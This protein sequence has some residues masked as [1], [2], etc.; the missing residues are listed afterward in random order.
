MYNLENFTKKAN[1]VIN[2]AFLQAGKLGHTYVGSEHLLLSLVSEQGSTAYNI[3]KS[4]GIR[5]D[6]VLDRLISLV[7][8]GDSTSV[9][10]NS[11]TPAARKTIEQSLEIA[12]SSG[13]RLAGTEHLLLSL[14]KQDNCT[15]LAIIRDIGGS[16][17]KIYNACAGL[18][19]VE[20]QVYNPILKAPTLMKYGRDLTQLAK[21][22]KCDPVF[23]RD[24][25]IER[26]MQILSRRTKNNPCL[27]GEA[28]VGKTAVV[29]GIAAL[30]AEGKV[31][32]TIKNKRIFS[33]NLT[34][35]LAGAKY[36]GDFEERIKQCIDEVIENGNIILFIDELHTIVGAGAAEGAIDAA[37]ILKPQLA[38]G[39]LQII[40]ATTIEE[41][42]KY[43]EKDSALERRFQQVLIKE[44]TPEEAIIIL[45]GLSKC[46]EDYHNVK[47][48][49]EA[50]SAAVKMSVRYIQ[51]RY[52]PDK[53]IDLID[54]AASRVR[55]KAASSPQSLKEL[56]ESLKQILEN[57]P[58][59]K[60]A[61]SLPRKKSGFDNT[62]WYSESEAK[63]IEVTEKD[64]AEVLSVTKGIPVTQ[65]TQDES[66]C[67]LSLES[68]LQKRVIGQNEAVKAVADAIRRSRS[69]LK[70]PCR[71]IG[72]FLFLGP[73]GVGKTELSKALA[74]CLFNEKNALI[75]FDMSEFM[76]KHSIAKLIGSPPG[77][78]G[79]D[80]GAQ[81]TEKVRRKP[82]SV[83][84]FDEIEK[85]HPDIFNILLQIFEDG[86]LTDST[87][88]TVSFRD[89][90]II[91][92]SNIGGNH[93]T[94]GKTVGFSSAEES[95]YNS[96]KHDVMNE[97]KNNFRPELL[98][99]IEE[100]IIF[101]RL[102]K[103]QLS[104]ITVK[105][106]ENL[107]ERANSLEIAVEFS[108]EAIQKLSE[109]GFDKNG[110]RKLRHIITTS[111]ENL[112]S[113]Q[114][115]EGT[116]K[117]GDNVILTLVDNNY[118]F[119]AKQLAT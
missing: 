87:G 82:Y 105:M 77:Y 111:V 97:L 30:I 73:T 75:R 101:N 5:E 100:I 58:I 80:D 7:G 25:E 22:K 114:I 24:K 108:D 40:G 56:A 118:K 94:D 72:T 41:Y 116:V 50:I 49:D 96:V 86:I 16:V 78:I 98:G 2:K 48:T 115:L 107:R 91:M 32:D 53:A 9:D 4:C 6:D 65:L 85:A 103:E 60:A 34:A 66:T 64:I 81:L 28:G 1:L 33:L 14:I 79:Y 37:N 18:S 44:P 20:T 8:R 10:M 29:E 76:E 113:K 83:I 62:S 68:E 99:R 112:L 55:M 42:R 92:T 51:D 31:P 36:R 57:Q 23:C 110:A 61:E 17:T 12:A 15:A 46:Y 19:T 84:L 45:K 71:P 26:V 35:M 104:L 109:E 54:E 93:I 3:L 88:R 52:L 70:D 39:D 21:D 74:E 102:N 89:T 11:I 95:S 67:L 117:K 63:T 27:I 69:G 43:I 13:S 47:I 38:R 119:K 59:K 106:L 90:V